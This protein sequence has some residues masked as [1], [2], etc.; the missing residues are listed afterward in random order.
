MESCLSSL[1]SFPFAS[2]PPAP[3]AAPTAETDVPAAQPARADEAAPH[4]EALGDRIADLAARIQ[5][6]TYELLVLIPSSTSA[7]AGRAS[8]PAPTG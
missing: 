6:A 8:P 4:V 7:A 5:A 2:V 1:A 3:P